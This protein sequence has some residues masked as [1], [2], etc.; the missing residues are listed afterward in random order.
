MTYH[1]TRQTNLSQ[2]TKVYKSCTWDVSD[3]INGISIP[4]YFL[5]TKRSQCLAFKENFIGLRRP[6]EP[7]KISFFFT[8]NDKM[9]NAYI[10]ISLLQTN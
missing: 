9:W 3:R 6:T 5:E 8:K 4:D 7:C 1:F 2:R 10:V